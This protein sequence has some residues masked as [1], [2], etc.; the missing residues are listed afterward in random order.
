[1][2]RESREQCEIHLFI[3]YKVHYLRPTYCTGTV[4]VPTATSRLA[5]YRKRSQILQ[6]CQQF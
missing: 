6:T 4:L 3:L 2:S 5:D 1:M